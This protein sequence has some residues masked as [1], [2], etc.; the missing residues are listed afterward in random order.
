MKTTRL[1]TL[2]LAVLAA[3]SS[4]A[5]AQAPKPAAAPTTPAAAPAVPPAAPAHQPGPPPGAPK[6]PGELDQLKWM[7]GN[8]RCEGKAP[9]GPMGPEHPYKST[10]R[11]KRDLD[12]FWYTSEYEQKKSKENPVAIKARSFIGFDPVAKKVVSVG[13]D[14]MGG[15]LQL[16]GTIEGDKVSNLGEGSVGGQKVGFKEV[17][18]KTGDRGLTWHGELRLGK[19]WQV[20]G[21]DVCKR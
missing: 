14:N 12:G 20:V 18:S 7:E 11:V 17:I 5:L 1:A 15:A 10:M 6:P 16:T 21:D 2:T 13:V 4:V 19:D 8:W 9:A 3:S